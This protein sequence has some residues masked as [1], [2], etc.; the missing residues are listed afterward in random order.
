MAGPIE[1]SGKRTL[2]RLYELIAMESWAKSFLRAGIIESSNLKLS[3][4]MV[5][6]QV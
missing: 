4:E 5:S 3:R 6:T 2:L 1:G